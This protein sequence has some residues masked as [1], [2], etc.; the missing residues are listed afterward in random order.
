MREWAASAFGEIFDRRFAEIYPVLADWTSHP[1][2]FVRRAALVAVRKAAKARHP[3]RCQ[4]L[5]ALVEP[6]AGDR[7]E[8]VRRNLG[9]FAIGDGLLK[10]YPDATLDRIRQ[11]ARSD[12]EMARWNAAMVFVTAAARRHID[13]GLDILSDLARD[14]RR[15][16]AYAVA[17][18]LRN[19]AKADPARVL[20]VLRTWLRDE[21]KL[22]AALAMRQRDMR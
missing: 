11:W 2:Q 10:A 5:L 21:R 9:P 1:S 3:E 8:E 7:A 12:D 20:P 6:L 18:A 13:A 17:A 4:P 16:V 19:L 22:P 15:T 14:Q